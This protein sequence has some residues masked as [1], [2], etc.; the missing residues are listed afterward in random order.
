MSPLTTDGTY[1]VT[2][3]QSDAATNTGSSGTES[4]TIAK[5]RAT[6][7]SVVSDGSPTTYGDSVTFTATV[8]A[9]LGDPHAQRQR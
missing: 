6:T 9:G 7:T 8:S 5:L 3:T 1:L 2:A 4:I